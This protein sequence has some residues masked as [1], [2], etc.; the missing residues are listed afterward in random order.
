[1]KRLHKG[2]YKLGFTGRRILSSALAVAV[3]ATLALT[4]ILPVGADTKKI[5]KTGL[6]EDQKIIHLLN[7]MAYGPRPGDVERVKRMGIDKYIDLQLHPERIDDPGIE[8]RLANFPSLR[9]SLAEI[10]Q[11]YPPPNILARELG[12]KQG[13]K[14]GLG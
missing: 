14:A 12:L 13:K 4:A 6:T 7:R 11:N 3:S 10:Q 9:M 5:A 8:A 1:M 2:S